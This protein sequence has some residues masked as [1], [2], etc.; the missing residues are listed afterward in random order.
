ME[1]VVL[2]ALALFVGT[3]I[4]TLLVVG[5]FCA[6]PDYRTEE[7]FVGHMAGFSIGLVAAVGGAIVAGE[8]LRDYT[9]LLGILPLGL[10]LWG[11]LRGPP[12]TTIEHT[13]SVPDAVGR[14]GV[15]TVAGIGLSGENIAVFVPFFAD[16]A[17]AE[18]AVVLGLYG[19]GAIGVFLVAL[20][21]VSQFVTDGISERLDRWL[22]SSVLVVVG[23][24]VIVSGLVVA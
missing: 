23:A 9:F 20:G 16:L 10:G 18:L 15:V 7:I 5:A 11:L 24:Y 21:A 3:H 17:A 22:V 2:V 13:P 6:D 1:T 12:E 14:I 19:L 8:L 4:D